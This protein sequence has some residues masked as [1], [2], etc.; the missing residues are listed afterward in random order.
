MNIWGIVSFAA[1]GA[2]IGNLT[3]PVDERDQQ[4]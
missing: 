3:A 1:L 2:C 4:G